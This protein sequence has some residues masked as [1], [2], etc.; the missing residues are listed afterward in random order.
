MKP[1]L[2]YTSVIIA[3]MA[4]LLWL[5]AWASG[6]M[7]TS[8]AARDFVETPAFTALA[9][10]GGIVVALASFAA[11]VTLLSLRPAGRTASEAAE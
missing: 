4:A 6:L 9:I 1:A 11:G 7:A 2:F 5:N 3:G 8:R 10:L